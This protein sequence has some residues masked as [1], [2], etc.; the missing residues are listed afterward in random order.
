MDTKEQIMSYSVGIVGATGVVG[1]VFLQ[2]L[3]TRRFPVKNLILYASDRSAGQTRKFQGKDVKVETLSPN[4]FKDLQLVFFS[5]GDD[6][7]KEWAPQ[8]VHAGAVAVDNSAAFR[9]DP[10]KILVVPE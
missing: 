9:M 7:S 5:S 6:I 4:C 1:E 10:E 3:E 2:L 8:A